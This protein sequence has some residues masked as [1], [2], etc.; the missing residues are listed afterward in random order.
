MGDGAVGVSDGVGSGGN[1][2]PSRRRLDQT[3]WHL[4]IL[5]AAGGRHE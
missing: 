1:E 2:L 5:E 4:E 3:H